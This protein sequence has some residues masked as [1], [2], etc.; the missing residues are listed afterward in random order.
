MPATEGIQKYLKTHDFRLRGND[1]KGRFKI[2]YEAIG[3]YHLK[4]LADQI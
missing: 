4:R 2:F 3:Y 1:V